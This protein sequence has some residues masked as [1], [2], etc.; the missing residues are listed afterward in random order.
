MDRCPYPFKSIQTPINQSF[1]KRAAIVKYEI[2]CLMYY[3]DLF[4]K[5]RK[6]YLA[7]LSFPKSN[8]QIQHSPPQKYLYETEEYSRIL[9]KNISF[10]WEDFDHKIE[11]E[12]I[13]NITLANVWYFVAYLNLDDCCWEQRRYEETTST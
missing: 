4:T 12:N 6:R 13:N 9:K 1:S 11:L 5:T 10:W 7:L 2:G 3:V 8:F